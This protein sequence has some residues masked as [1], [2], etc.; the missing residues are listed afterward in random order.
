[1]LPAHAHAVRRVLG[2]APAA[3]EPHSTGQAPARV[4][5]ELHLRDTLDTARSFGPDGERVGLSYKRSS[6][7]AVAV[8]PP[9]PDGGEGQPSQ[10]QTPVRLFSLINS[11]MELTCVLIELS[12][13]IGVADICLFVSSRPAVGTLHLVH[14]VLVRYGAATRGAVKEKT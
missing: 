14:R 13:K 5:L 1:M 7:G 4:V 3:V 10:A 11:V 8:A 6:S 9:A 2:R 12:R